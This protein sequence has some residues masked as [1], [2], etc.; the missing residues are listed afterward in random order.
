[1]VE[2]KKTRTGRL[3]KKVKVERGDHTDEEVNRKEQTV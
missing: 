1:V 2:K 3:K